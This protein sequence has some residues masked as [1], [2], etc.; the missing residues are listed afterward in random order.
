VETLTKAL[1]DKTSQ[2]WCLDTL[3]GQGLAAALAV[4]HPGLINLLT[5]MLGIC[6]E[7]RQV[8]GG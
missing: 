1:H 4:G 7:V 8:R 2:L 5:T 3:A 6:A